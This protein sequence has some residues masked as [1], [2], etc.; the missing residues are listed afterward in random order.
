MT[1]EEKRTEL[2]RQQLI[3]IQQ[4]AQPT[5]APRPGSD[6]S[7]APGTTP[8]QASRIP[9]G[10]VYDPATGGYVD[11]ALMAERMGAPY[12]AG[13]VA[14]SGL[15]FIGEWTDEAAGQID[16]FLTGRS[17]EIQ[18]ELQRQAA[19]QFTE[20]RP[21]L[22]PALK[23]GGGLAGTLAA[24]PL[25]GPGIKAAGGMSKIAQ[26]LL[27]AGLGAAGGATEG[28]FQGAG[29]ANDGDRRAGA[30]GGAVVGGTAGAVLGGLAPLAATGA[31]RAAD[32]IS[33][34][35][36]GRSQ[37][38][39]GM[40]MPASER[41]LAAASAD[42]VAARGL[43]RVQSAGAGA[44][45]ADIGPATAD[46]LD[47]AV[48]TSPAGATARDAITGRASDAST[49]LGAA[50]DNVLG[51]AEG[52]ATIKRTIRESTQPGIRDAYQ[53]AYS[54]A[55]DY[56]SDAG[57]KVED[58]FSRIPDRY[59]RQ[60]MQR[61]NDRM[62]YDN[63]PRQMLFSI[64]DDGGI[65]AREMPNLMQLDYL[66]RALDDV[67]GDGVNPLTGGMTSD[68]QFASRLA[69]DLRDALKDAVPEY[70]VA[71]DQASDAFSLQR[72][73]DLG[74]EILSPRTKRDFVE[75][76]AKSASDADRRALLVALRSD[77][78]E[79]MA[80]VTRAVADGEMDIREAR[81][82]IRDMSSRAAREK[83]TSVLGEEQAGLI[84]KALDEAADA[85]GLLASVAGNSATARRITTEKALSESMDYQPA[86]IARDTLSSPLV[87]PRRVIEVASNNTA[88]DRF[89]RQQDV[90]REIVDFL[91]R[92]QNPNAA[93][94][95]IVDA[96]T[97]QRQQAP[98]STAIGQGAASLSVP[99]YL[100]ATQ[101]QR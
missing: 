79:R 61:A 39:P 53:T 69:R 56:A 12:G 66:K 27:G 60:A 77:I 44:M 98:I 22:S 93:V 48:N 78:D 47:Y 80:N 89:S 35:M 70:R 54:R 46:L 71:L 38:I 10:M 83:L 7:T 95:S 41:I 1:P 14:A 49:R 18:T 19:D 16:A 90:T 68:G 92:R 63:L 28:A 88:M 25:A 50:F 51:G 26:V 8:A 96:L 55:I 82:I 9:D 57:R 59:M 45:P 37:Q 72:A 87:G 4:A 64:G 36:T 58:I 2:R 5:G 84:L 81:K 86:Q 67:A 101:G 20:E 40:S 32:W 30:E 75:D 52:V 85:Q 15:P 73:T 74:A 91:T 100:L 76:W 6:L 3:A 34:R 33:D 23:L 62:V 94:Q 17:P 99:G 29:A 11:T 43:S 21:V 97:R 31:R 24:L 42:D 65:A 13:A